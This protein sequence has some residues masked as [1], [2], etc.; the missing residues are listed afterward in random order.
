MS[1]ARFG[2]PIQTV[3]LSCVMGLGF[4]VVISVGILKAG[5]V[6]IRIG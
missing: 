6:L 5:F 1:Q 4:L 3:Y 2:E